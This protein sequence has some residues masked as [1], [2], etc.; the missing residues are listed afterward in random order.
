MLPIINIG[1]LS[2]P[3]SPLIL[4]AGLWLGTLLMS[5]QAKSRGRP[6]DTLDQILWSSLAVGLVGARLSYIARNPW[7]FKGQVLSIFS[8]NPALLDLV[9]GT[10]IALAAGYYLISKNQLDVRKTLDDFV[11]LL[12]VLAPAIYLARFASGDGFGSVTDLP[13]GINLWGAIRHPVQLYYLLGG[14]TVV[15]L[16]L[17]NALKHIQIPG[18]RF[19]LFLILSAG[20]LA[21]LS[22]FQDPA[23]QVVGRFRLPQLGYW[24]I[25]TLSL[26]LYPSQKIG[27]NHGNA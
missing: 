5:R 1:P 17:S 27:E 14:L 18:A 2:L 25:F 15:V 11:P 12:A 20:Y 24:A 7:A 16:V 10:L 9:G 26:L 22:A 4:L 13:W 19:T 21:I 23:G 3:A 8:L 6:Q